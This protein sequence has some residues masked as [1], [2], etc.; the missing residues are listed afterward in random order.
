MSGGSGARWF[1]IADDDAARLSLPSADGG[2]R[3]LERGL[4]LVEYPDGRI[5][6]AADLLPAQGAIGALELP[7]RLGAGVV[8]YATRDGATYLWRAPSWTAP[9][10]QMTRLPF[11]TSSFVAGF[12]RLYATSLRTR[13][14]VGVDAVTGQLI[15]QGAIPL[16]P[17]YGGLA[18]SDAWLGAVEVD[19]RGAL[20]TFDAGSSFHPVSTP[21]ATP[22]VFE[23]GGR[24]V[25]GTRQGA[26]SVEPSG[27]LLRLDGSSADAAFND[28]SG[29]SESTESTDDEGEGEDEAV[30]RTRVLGLRP[31]EVAAL[32]GL[33]E[34]PTTAVVISNGTLARVDV[35]DGRIV[36]AAPHAV[37]A[38]TRC[39]AIRL[40][41]GIGFAC[42]EYGGRT[43]LYA[44]RAPLGVSPVKTFP[45]PRVVSPAGNG[46][47]VVSG[48]CADRGALAGSYCVL[49]R[50]GTTFD[51]RVAGPDPS[52][53]VVALSDGRAAVIKPPRVGVPGAL[54]LESATGKTE[55]RPLR[56]D[57]LSR[58]AQGLVTRG[59]WLDGVV[60][61]EPG[62]LVVWVAGSTA[63]VGLRVDLDGTV[64]AGTI[65]RGVERT[66]FAGVFAL[67]FDEQGGGHESED[68]GRTWS[69]IDVPG[70]SPTEARSPL[71]PVLLGADIDHGAPG[72]E[73]GCTAVGC[74]IGSWVRIGWNQHGSAG[75]LVAVAEPPGAKLEPTP[76]VTWS[77]DCTPSGEH[78]G[79]AAIAEV[80]PAPSPGPHAA[81]RA[82]LGATS[83]GLESSAFR[84]FL[85][86]P[87]PARAPLDL[88]F[89]FGT[90]DRPIQ[91]RGYAWG[92][93]GAAWDR[94]GTWLVRAADRFAVRH[95]VWSTAASR[96]PFVDAAAAAE[97]FGS[98]PTHRITNDWRAVLDPTGE[99]GA[100]VMRTGVESS[101]AII[102]RDRAIGVIKKADDFAL[103][104]VGSAVKVGGRWYLGVAPG[105]RAF[106]ILGVD[107]GALF[108]VASFPRFS[109][110][111]ADAGHLV[112]TPRGDALGV[113]IVQHGYAGMRGGG[114]TWFIY[115]VDLS[116]GTAGAP[117]IVP[118]NA[119]AHAPRPCDPDETGWVL[120]QDVSP[121]IGRVELGIPDAPALGHL[122]AR[123]VAGPTGLCVDG[124]AAQVDGDPPEEIGP[125]GLPLRR[126]VTLAVTD[127]ATDR[128]WGFRCAP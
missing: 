89:D 10:V 31:L 15:G 123:L 99:G 49:T 81:A 97:A 60:E 50:A 72:H 3:L 104:R 25:L 29:V 26:F 41:A 110:E 63:F 126:G 19:I 37:P 100:L 39:Q 124:L 56:L 91:V 106:Q 48:G 90:E 96:S 5:E 35:R 64:T 79:P 43:T 69:D 118:R 8:F 128:R 40:G 92:P 47:V 42:G 74:S 21:M 32:R 125:H 95:A 122:E 28:V 73:H 117:L 22:G 121:S 127:R 76:I 114:D 116:T 61:P 1:P 65:R 66:S 84:P 11:E 78:E 27:S 20:V 101:L 46:A 113:W 87:S 107:A 62:H 82:T 119:L 45:G 83:D 6:R 34:Y 68:G 105:P 4:R 102:E 58:D 9:L 120:V 23:Q 13:A 18:F 103:D 53:R 112:R 51:A 88:G 109:D 71:L 30:V 111:G 14:V 93:R 38:A 24:V 16:A 94:E 86:T 54:T 77:F 44:L 59:S 85:G 70:A 67:G 2:L 36:E 75:D 98:E 12:D 7:Q 17:A 80:R 57:A 33:P 52:V 55:Q 108:P 115:P